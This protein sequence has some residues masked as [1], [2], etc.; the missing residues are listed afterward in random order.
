MVISSC[1]SR[2]LSLYPKTDGIGARAG[3]N[4]VFLVHVLDSYM[5]SAL[6]LGYEMSFVPGFFSFTVQG[7]VLICGHAYDI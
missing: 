6:P 5:W 1:S 7:R 3:F 4:P 2:I